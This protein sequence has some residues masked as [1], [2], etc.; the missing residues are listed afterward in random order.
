[1]GITVGEV[2]TVLRARDEMSEAFTRGGQSAVDLTGKL[3][4][5]QAEARNAGAELRNLTSA[6]SDMGQGAREKLQGELEQTSQ[7]LIEART[8][9]SGLSAELKATNESASKLSSTFAAEVS[10]AVVSA[11]DAAKVLGTN[12]KESADAFD[13]LGGMATRIVERMAIL[14]ALRGTFKFVEDIIAGAHE[15]E[16]LAESLDMTTTK[17]QELQYAATQTDVPFTTLTSAADHLQRALARD[18]QSVVKALTDVGIKFDD[19]R[20][21]RGGEA[22]DLAAAAV[23]NLGDRVTRAGVEMALF[24]TDKVD[25]AVKKL[26]ELEQAARDANVV[27]SDGQIKALDELSKKW[28][29]LLMKAKAYVATLVTP[30]STG[31]RGPLNTNTGLRDNRTDSVLRQQ[32]EDMLAGTGAPAGF[33]V[34][35]PLTAPDTESA[36]ARANIAATERELTAQVQL[37]IEREIAEADA[38]REILRIQTEIYKQTDAEDKKRAHIHDLLQTDA[39]MAEF[40]ARETVMAGRG[41]DASG[42][43]PTT[44]PLAAMNKQMDDL[45]REKQPGVSQEF[46]EQQIFDEF[47]KAQQEGTSVVIGMSAAERDATVNATALS[48]SHAGAAQSSDALAQALAKFAGISAPAT[49]NIEE[50][51]RARQNQIARNPGF[52]NQNVLAGSVFERHFAAGGPTTEGPAYVHDDEYVVPKG[53]ALVKGGAGGLTV[54]ITVIGATGADHAALAERIATEFRARLGQSHRF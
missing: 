35:H 53:G 23:A 17:V 38:L 46:Q 29:T 48:R 52:I 33:Q 41:L 42:K 28:D 9:V 30:P 31:A 5:A 11:S 44:D 2:V 26:H 51:I 54:N 34:P 13:K 32:A 21:K 24:G 14:Y 47:I 3:A 22:F 40:K 27:L 7:K 37:K 8:R 49:P 25:P 39:V 1:M 6:M 4:L 45:H 16:M 43:V 50:S 20:S 19:I 12:A 10:P 15:T 18:D 36:S